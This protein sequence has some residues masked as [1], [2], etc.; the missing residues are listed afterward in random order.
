MKY[1]EALSQT[2]WAFQQNDLL[3]DV[4]LDIKGKQLQAHKLILTANSKFFW[5]VFNTNDSVTPHCNVA[6]FEWGHLVEIVHFMYTGTMKASHSSMHTL[7][8]MAANLC[9]GVVG[10]VCKTYL[11]YALQNTLTGRYM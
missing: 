3:C 5:D 11:E 4:T 6:D 7:R 8:D 1:L 9:V 10:G 2:L